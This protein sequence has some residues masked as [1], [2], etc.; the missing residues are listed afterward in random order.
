LVDLSEGYEITE[1]M[2]SMDSLLHMCSG[3]EE[4]IV[5]AIRT[6][7]MLRVFSPQRNGEAEFAQ[8]NVSA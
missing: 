4:N 3:F 1:T 6:V 7:V 5:R 8:R 2:E